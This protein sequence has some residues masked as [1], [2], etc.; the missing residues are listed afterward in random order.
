MPEGPG[1]LIPLA[2]GVVGNE[3]SRFSDLPGCVPSVILT[4]F[5]P[6]REPST[7]PMSLARPPSRRRFRLS[8]ATLPRAGCERGFRRGCRRRC[9]QAQ[10]MGR[11]WGGLPIE[12][13]ASE[14]TESE[15]IDESAI[16]CETNLRELQDRQA[17]R[18]APGD[19]HQSSPQATTGL[20][21]DPREQSLEAAPGFPDRPP[22][23]AIDGDGNE[24]L[25]SLVSIF[26][27]TSVW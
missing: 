20:T 27:T 6:G 15:A 12:P 24:C 3:G 1:P 22:Q 25:V 17:G 8:R 14:P 7:P 19:L 23:R 13:R 16:E 5:G 26:P 18:Q 4:K 9:E 10:A 2:P 11:R 21:P